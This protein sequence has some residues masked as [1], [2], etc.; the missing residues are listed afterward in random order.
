MINIFPIWCNVNFESV[1][2][3]INN[4]KIREN[5]PK[6]IVLC[7]LMNNCLNRSCLSWVYTFENSSNLSWCTTVVCS[8]CHKLSTTVK[9]IRWVFESWHDKTNKM[10]GQPAKTQISLGICPVWSR[11]FAVHVKKARVL[12]YPLSAQLRLIRLGRCPGW[13]VFTVRTVTLLVLSRHGSFD[14]SL[15]IIFHISL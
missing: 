15:R 12:S 9:Q 13:W 11:V 3:A 10:C 14:D 2:T 7:S 4:T 5:S 6:S 8:H 1:F